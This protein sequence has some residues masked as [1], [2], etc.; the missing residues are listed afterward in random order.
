MATETATATLETG[1]KV[2]VVL[3]DFFYVHLQVE[4]WETNEELEA[5]VPGES[6]REQW[7]PSFLI[8]GRRK[9]KV[10]SLPNLMFPITGILEECLQGQMTNFYTQNWSLLEN[11]NTPSDSYELFWWTLEEPN[12]KHASFLHWRKRIFRGV[13]VSYFLNSNLSFPFPLLV[14]ELKRETDAQYHT[15]MKRC[16][17]YSLGYVACSLALEDIVQEN[18]VFCSLSTKVEQIVGPYLV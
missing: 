16:Q 7:L 1:D 6:V 17:D 10:T 11:V 13:L 9:R 15:I 12:E 8:R 3:D 5:I 18:G 14:A 4:R 2:K